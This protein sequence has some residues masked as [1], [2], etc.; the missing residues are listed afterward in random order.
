MIIQTS[1]M[2]KFAPIVGDV[3]AKLTERLT[4]RLK[5]P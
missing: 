5:A 4:G 2:G 3:S 1:R